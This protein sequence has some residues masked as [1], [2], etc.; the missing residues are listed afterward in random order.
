VQIAS[1]IIFKAVNIVSL[2][3]YVANAAGNEK[4][5]IVAKRL[6]FTLVNWLNDSGEYLKLFSA[7][8]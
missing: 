1:T 5:E 2:V 6:P 3:I 8:H 7:D 4:P